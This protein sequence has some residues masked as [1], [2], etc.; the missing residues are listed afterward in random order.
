MNSFSKKRVLQKQMALGRTPALVKK[1]LFGT[2]I[3]RS[4][5]RT[6]LHKLATTGYTCF[7]IS[8]SPHRLPEHNP[9]FISRQKTN[10]KCTA[11]CFLPLLLWLSLASVPSRP[12]YNY[13]CPKDD[14]MFTLEAGRLPVPSPWGAASQR[15][16]SWKA[17]QSGFSSAQTHKGADRTAQDGEE[18]TANAEG[19]REG[20]SKCLFKLH[21][22]ASPL[23]LLSVLFGKVW[24]TSSRRRV[25][26]RFWESQNECL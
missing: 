14:Y 5:A 1:N 20:E 3:S 10:I 9:S 17:P 16:S 7:S 26:W 18:D 24:P 25:E 8:L 13:S 21:T 6:K 11:F 22:R 12:R 2:L 15:G 4:V 19:G 23:R